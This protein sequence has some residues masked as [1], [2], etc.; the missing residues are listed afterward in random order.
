[1]KNKISAIKER[2][3]KYIEEGLDF[4]SACI[5]SGI[6]E[7]TGYYWKKKDFSFF[8]QCEAANAKYIQK[9]I[10][11]V[12][13]EAVRDG[14]VALQVL[15]IRCPEIWDPQKKI[16]IYDPASELQ[17]IHELIYEGKCPRELH[18]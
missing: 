12:N 2:I 18:G 15:K 3:T 7:R 14:K 6:T 5:S 8:S 4:K 17:R 1:M 10:T 13:Q 11:C 16:Q 9:L